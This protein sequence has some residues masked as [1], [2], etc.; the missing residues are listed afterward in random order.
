[1]FDLVIRN[2][3]IV[4]GSGQPSFCGDVAIRGEWV[5][6]MGTVTHRGAREIDAHGKLVTP[7]F[8]DIQTHYDGQLIWSD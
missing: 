7:G 5:A 8:T 1:M 2:G 6:E 3:T 4:E